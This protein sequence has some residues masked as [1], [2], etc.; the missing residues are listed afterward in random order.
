M[1]D[2][3]IKSLFPTGAGIDYRTDEQKEKDWRPEEAFAFASPVEWKGK[4]LEEIEANIKATSISQWYTSRCVPEYA[5]IALEMAELAESGKKVI[6]SRR[7]IYCRRNNRPQ[8]GM[9]MADLFV[10]MRE[11]ACLEE[12]LPSTQTYEIEISQPYKVTEGMI[13][14]RA[15]Y[16]SGA[17][18][19]WSRWTIDNIAQMIQQGTPVCIFWYFDGSTYDEWWNAKPKVVDTK[20]GMFDP[21]TARHQAT[22]I[23][24][25]L[26]DG[27]K[28]L[29]V[30]D[31]AGQGTGT[32][33]KKNIRFVSEEF[34]NIRSYGA[35]FAIDKKNLDHKP[36]ESFTYNFDHDLKY[37][38][39]ED[40]VMAL[41]KI[42]I[43]EGCLVLNTPTKNFL[44]M[45]LAGVKKLQNK[46]A[47][48]ILYPLGLKYGTGYFGSSTRAFINSKYN[49]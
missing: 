19:T 41:Q 20:L 24:F 13:K 47:K 42:L 36:D 39:V 9:G 8:E 11:G 3:E 1:Q 45:T 46:Y 5:G 26:I 25:C 32:G 30:M 23:D 7:D 22:A 33:A 6:F 48:E 15:T 10:L 14:A 2:Q 12:Q 21:K 18:F 17:S 40:D 43:L 44:G 31:S 29:I 35:G 49:K 38:M 16:A 4:T 28:Y 34:L 37:G 27:V